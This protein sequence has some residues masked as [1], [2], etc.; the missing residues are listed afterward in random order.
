ME[1]DLVQVGMSS[2]SGVC[3]RHCSI[4]EGMDHHWMPDCDEDTGEPVMVCKHCDV[5]RPYGDDDE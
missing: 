5:T 4:C 2:A 3:E 1:D